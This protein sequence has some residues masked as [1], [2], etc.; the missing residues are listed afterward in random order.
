MM[1]MAG[2]MYPVILVI[3]KKY[4]KQMAYRV[5]IPFYILGGVLLVSMPWARMPTMGWL[6]P[7]FTII[8]GIGFSG[9]QLMPWLMFPDTVDIAEFKLGTR[10]T[11][12]FS[13]MM[14]FS[15]KVANAVAV[16][17]V[18]V[19]LDL[20]GQIPDTTNALGESVRHAQPA[21]VLLAIRLIMG[22]SIAVILSIAFIISLKYKVTE[23]KLTR[24]RYF[25]D[26]HKENATLSPEEE[27]E[28]ETLLK[29]LT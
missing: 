8:M 9:A 24:V 26:K 21:S 7:I 5:G 13:S 15:R 23:P 28:K 3:M 16:L 19:I 25:L 2:A 4:S 12:M 22:I 18:G 17:I 20:A 6:V 1:V 14:T 27:T 11:G 10:Q 29:E